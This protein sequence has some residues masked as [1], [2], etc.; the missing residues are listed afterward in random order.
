LET[1]FGSNRLF[2]GLLTP[3]PTAWPNEQFLRNHDFFRVPCLESIILR[4]IAIFMDTR[5]PGESIILMDHP[6]NLSLTTLRN[7]CSLRDNS[8]AISEHQLAKQT[9]TRRR[10]FSSCQTTL[11]DDL[12][13]V[14][15]TSRFLDDPSDIFPTTL[16]RIHSD[17]DPSDIF[18]TTLPRIRS[19][20][21]PS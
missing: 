18:S 14:D 13:F 15:N 20:D 9:L 8:P 4:R 1:S 6:H 12:S 2:Y 17:D 11:F 19:D 16:P 7:D 3:A 10:C 21:D 5:Q